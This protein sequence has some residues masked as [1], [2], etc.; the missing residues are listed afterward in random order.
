MNTSLKDLDFNFLVSLIIEIMFENAQA[1]FNR[2]FTCNCSKINLILESAIDRSINQCMVLRK[3][4]KQN[5]FKWDISPCL[6]RVLKMALELGVIKDM[7][8]THQ[9][10]LRDNGITNILVLA[11]SSVNE[12]VSTG[13]PQD[14]AEIYITKAMKFAD[15]HL[16]SNK[17]FIT[18]DELIKMFEKRQILSSGCPSLDAILDG[19]FETQKIYEV[20]GPKGIGKSSLCHQ[21]IYM[22]MLPEEKGGLSNPATVYFDC[23]Q[24][25]SSRK[26]KK[27]ASYYNIDPVG[28]T[29]SVILNQIPTTDHLLYSVEKGLFDIMEQTGARLIVC[30]SISIHFRSEYGTLR[31]MLPERQNKLA[32]VLHQFKRAANI[33]NAVVLLTNQV[34]A[35][36]TGKGSPYAPAG[37]HVL[38]H[39]SQV[40]IRITTNAKILKKV[41]V[42]KAV[43][44]PKG[45]CILEL[46]QWG[47]TEVDK[48]KLKKGKKTEEDDSE[49]EDESSEAEEG[50]DNGENS[51]EAGELEDPPALSFSDDGSG[52][53]NDKSTKKTTKKTK[54]TKKTKD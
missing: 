41:V 39:G 6:T 45:E 46:N 43:D 25:F 2:E 9:K 8:P 26:M 20:Y 16:G 50:S 12:L 3:K 10:K 5:L 15:K 33:Y 53:G 29:K 22:S 54:K 14:K 38:G 23:E 4:K 44:L 48:K 42:E 17:G 47:F 49:S 32:R 1:I 28:A 37:G 51:V 24:S 18:G 30:D 11:T 7:L 36:V 19:G 27:M 52:S 21:L 40:R 31:Q 13:I 34:A 35:N